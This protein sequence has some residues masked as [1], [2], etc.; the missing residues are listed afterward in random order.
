MKKRTKWLAVGLLMTSFALSL[1]ACTDDSQSSSGGNNGDGSSITVGGDII[2]G[3]ENEV[4]IIGAKNWHIALNAQVDFAEGVYAQVGDDALAVTVDSSAVNT[5]AQGEYVIKYSFEN[6]VIEKKVFVYGEISFTD[7]TPS[8]TTKYSDA[9]V[10][11]YEGFTAKDSFGAA[12][13]VQL[14]SSGGMLNTDGTLNIGTFNAVFLVVDNAGQTKKLTRSVTVER[15]SAPTLA[16][17]LTYD[18]ADDYLTV[19]LENSNITGISIDGKLATLDYVEIGEDT[20]VLDGAWI[21]SLCKANESISLR[22]ISATGWVESV[23][24]VTDEKAVQYDDTAIQEF[25]AKYYACDLETAFPEIVLTNRRQ[26]VTPVYSFVYGGSS[27]VAE[28]VYTFTKSGAYE[29]QVDLRGDILRYEIETYFDLGLKDGMVF[30]RETG[31]DVVHNEAYELLGY[32]LTDKKGERT[33]AEYRV[34][35]SAFSLDEFNAA[36]KSLNT[37]ENYRLTATAFKGSTVIS[38][39]VD[40]YVTAKAGQSVLSEKA[41]GDNG[42]MYAWKPD[43]VDL[44]YE[45]KQVGGRRGAFRWKSLASGE[46]SNENSILSFD[47]AFISKMKKGTYLTFDIY[48]DS[49]IALFFYVNG[50]YFY[51]WGNVAGEY[52]FAKHITAPQ[53]ST[54]YDT[55]EAF[56]KVYDEKGVQI[57]SGS[58]GGGSFNN[59]WVTVE[60]CLPEDMGMPSS[61]GKYNYNGFAI[62][63]TKVATGSVT[64]KNIYLSNVRISESSVMTDSTVNPVVPDNADAGEGTGIIVDVWLGKDEEIF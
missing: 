25:A 9:L 47:S 60:I 21:Y 10:E 32:A 7:T 17:T 46:V 41:D 64:G 18:V 4:S 59:K 11:I 45:Y 40:C 31:F 16:S 38:Q 58:F 33:Y 49:A 42:N 34:G 39:T 61:D 62:Y 63:P 15:E 53:G 51:L 30:D 3:V 26:T 8:V 48:T 24:T 6:T 27:A 54:S 23:L 56:A 57:T 14:L 44:A 36:V 19:D 12:L 22:L 43:K 2:G 55:A 1:G 37:V 50:Y 5:A 28:G 20:L 52:Y 35:S 13:D 29:L